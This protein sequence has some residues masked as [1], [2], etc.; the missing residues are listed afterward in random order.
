MILVVELGWY[1]SLL[2]F[3]E[4]KSRAIYLNTDT[5]WNKLGDFDDIH[6]RTAHVDCETNGLESIIS[7]EDYQRAFLGPMRERLSEDNMLIFA[8]QIA[9]ALEHLSKCAVSATLYY[10]YVL[11]VCTYVTTYN[12]H[13]IHTTQYSRFH[14]LTTLTMCFFTQS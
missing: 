6:E 9:L 2:P 11:Y 5:T 7:S 12:L 4:E 3:L 14:P 1:G 10:I 13:Y 8:L